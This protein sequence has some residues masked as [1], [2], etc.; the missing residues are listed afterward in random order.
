MSEALILGLAAP[1]NGAACLLRGDK[2]LVAI[3]E[4]RLRRQKRA[5]LIPSQP[6]MALDYVM[7]T[8]GII[9]SRESTARSPCQSAC[10]LTL[11]PA[12]SDRE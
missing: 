5:A 6:F 3:Q 11:P 7:E 2:V 9:Y 12:D 10:W 4:E 8:A 1:H